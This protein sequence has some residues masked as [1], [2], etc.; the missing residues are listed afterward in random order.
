MRKTAYFVCIISRSE[1]PSETSSVGRDGGGVKLFPRTGPPRPGLSPGASSMSGPA[2][3]L[4][5]ARGT[6]CLL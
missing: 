1:I 3:P 5:W 2:P 6:N 4:P